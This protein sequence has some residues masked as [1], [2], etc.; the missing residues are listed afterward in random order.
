M[1]NRLR[2]YLVNNNFEFLSVNSL[3]IRVNS[4]FECYN[5]RESIK[6]D[7]EGLVESAIIEII[8]KA[9]RARQLKKRGH[10]KLGMMRHVY[11]LVDC[12]ESMNF[13]DLKPTRMICTSKVLQ[14]EL[15]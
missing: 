14:T 9:K 13:P 7:D 4:I 8:Q 2:T 5:F 1:G 12:S 6:E 11:L 15:I 3:E 10:R